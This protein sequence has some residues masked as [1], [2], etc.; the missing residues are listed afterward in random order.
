VTFAGLPGLSNGS[1]GII[2][3]HPLWLTDRAG[4]GPEVAA[5]WDD[6]ERNHGL[7]VD[8]SWSFVSVFEALRR[9]A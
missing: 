1:D 7:Q 8:P 3:T 2:V 5:A 4:A 6:A 9:P